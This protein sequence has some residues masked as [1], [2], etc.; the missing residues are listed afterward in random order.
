MKKRWYFGSRAIA[1][2]T[3]YV[4]TGEHQKP[5]QVICDNKKRFAYGKPL[6]SFAPETDCKL[7]FVQKIIFYESQIKQNSLNNFLY[8]DMINL[9]GG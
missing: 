5:P 7:R 8:Y 2:S 4:T 6:F 9:Y 1:P 3:Y